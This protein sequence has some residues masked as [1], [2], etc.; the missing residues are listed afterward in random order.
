MHAD[1]VRILE[2]IEIEPGDMNLVFN[3]IIEAGKR[4]VSTTE[5]ENQL[6]FHNRILWMTEKLDYILTK[7]EEDERIHKKKRSTVTLWF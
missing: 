2:P 3:V 7:L 1:R 4:G 5:I 6:R